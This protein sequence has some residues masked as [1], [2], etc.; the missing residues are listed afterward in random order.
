MKFARP[1][2]AIAVLALL[3]SGQ[4]SASAEPSEGSAD[5]KVS[6]SG[7]RDS[8]S[9]S[10]P[11]VVDGTVRIPNEAPSAGANVVLLAWPSNEVVEKMAIND[12]LTLQPVATAVTASDG[13][14]QLRLDSNER[15][16]PMAD[17]Y[18]IVNFDIVASPADP[19]SGQSGSSFSFSRRLVDTAA[20]PV[21][22][23][24]NTPEGEATPAPATEVQLKSDGTVQEVNPE[25]Q[26]PMDE[27]AEVIET[28]P[29]PLQK[30]GDTVCDVSYVQ[31]LGPI[32]VLVGQTFNV[33]TWMKARFTYI[34]GSSSSLGVGI[35][36]SGKAGTFSTHGSSSRS[37]TTTLGYGEHGGT[38][39]RYFDT[40]FAFGKYF[41]KCYDSGSGYQW[42]FYTIRNNGFIGSTRIR[43]LNFAPNATHCSP[44]A[45]NTFIEKDETR[46]V[47]WS[48]GVELTG[49]GMGF[50]STTGYNNSSKLYY[51]ATKYNRQMCGLYAVPGQKP[52]LLV[53]K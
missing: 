29:A 52:G 31:G 12:K 53:A 51:E 7:L 18:G 3:G 38:T 43:K 20:G 14:F 35:S 23:D 32:W 15:I 6:A 17:S 49:M 26:L 19:A 45:A 46:A 10:T 48:N 42:S 44:L 21:L 40:Q 25:P 41:H 39:K 24:V 22:A 11:V 9:L 27:S 30:D 36:T 34:Q 2:A 16:R 50:S 47:T 5:A 28:N 37:S 33:A 1:V 4:Y 13:S 8:A